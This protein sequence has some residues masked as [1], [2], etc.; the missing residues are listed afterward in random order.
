[1]SQHKRKL[2]QAERERVQRNQTARRVANYAPLPCHES[3]STIPNAEAIDGFKA[4]LLR[5]TAIR[6]AAIHLA[7]AK[8][9]RR[10]Q[11]NLV[12]LQRLQNAGGQETVPGG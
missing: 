4:M 12:D 8:R 3:L 7:H 9:V 5:K 2:H 10:W 11:R 1:M 6:E